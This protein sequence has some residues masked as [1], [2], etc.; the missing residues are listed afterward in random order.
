MFWVLGL[1]CS[2]ESSGFFSFLV[3]KG[4]VLS[5]EQSNPDFRVCRAKRKKIFSLKFSS[6]MF[7]KDFVKENKKSAYL[8]VA[9]RSSTR[10]A[11]QQK[12]ETFSK[13]NQKTADYS[14][15]QLTLQNKKNEHTP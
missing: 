4:A 9:G 3:Y 5:Q 8:Y 6:E 10:R 13:E 15:Q 12:V 7:L 1:L 2:Q 11:G 14:V